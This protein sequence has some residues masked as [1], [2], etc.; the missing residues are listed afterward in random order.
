MNEV[1]LE[2]CDKEPI[3][4]PGAVQPHGVL[5]ALQSSNG[6]ISHLSENI[7]EVF[8]I[9]AADLLGKPIETLFQPEEAEE[10]MRVLL[11]EVEDEKP[12]YLYTVNI[13]NHD[14]PFDAIAHRNGEVLFIEFEP[15]SQRRDLS[16]P[17]LYRLVQQSAIRMQQSRVVEDLMRMCAAQVRKIN[18]FDRVMIYR[19]D[20]EW[21]G[22]VLAED[23]RDDLEPFLNLHYPASDIPK[24]ARELY[25]KNLLRFITSR[26]YKPA[27]ILTGPDFDS[28][29]PLDLSFSVLRSVSPIHLEYLRNMGVWA[30]MS[31]SLIKDGRLWGLIAC[32]HY[33]GPRF[34]SYD[35]R[36]ACELLG[37][38]LSLH[39]AVVEE[40]EKERAREEKAVVRQELINAL[41]RSEDLIQALLKTRPTMLDLIEADGA[42]IVTDKS[43]ARIGQTPGPDEIKKLCVWL[44]EH[45]PDEIIAID[46]LDRAFGSRVFGNVAA[47]VLAITL[48][49]STRYKLLWFRSELIRTVNWA[50]DPAK[51]VTKGDGV[52]RLSPRGSFALWKETIKGRCIP[53]NQ[54]NLDAAQL[55]HIDLTKLLLKRTRV[56]ELAHANL[57]IASEEREKLLDSERAA[58]TQADR[59][60]RIKDDFLA[61]LSHELR[62]P[63]NSILGW[64]VLLLDRGN[65]EDNVKDGLKVI[66]RSARS[67]AG[68]IEDLLDMSRII[69]GKLRLDLQ[70]T[71]L[72]TVV[73]ASIETVKLAADAKDIRVERLIDPL[74]GLETTGDP[75]R[76]Q[77][78]VWNLL[79]NAVKFTP[80]KG[81]I[82]LFLERVDSHVELTVTDNGQGIS[83]IELPYIF[84]RFHQV[85]NSTSRQHGGLGLGL[86]I[87]RNLVELHGGTIRASSPGEGK[88]ATF[89]VAL[90]VRVLRHHRDFEGIEDLSMSSPPSHSFT[91][92]G[93]NVLVVDDEDDARNLIRRMLE[94]YECQVSVVGSKQ[95]AIELLSTEK[96]DVLI[97][98]IGM[99]GED[100]YTLIKNWRKIESQ[101][102]KE[103]T[104]AIAL[105]AYVRSKDRSHSLLSGFQAHLGKPVESG[106][107]LAVV[108][109]LTGRI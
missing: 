49:A 70:P 31:V 25:T 91:L 68:M 29:S 20:A 95:E 86:S 102:G 22:V 61:T 45:S 66:E 99:P 78:I 88:G 32:H 89:V 33:D 75:N 21:N 55:L 42:A 67:Q 37:Q 106:E 47:G 92:S 2:N 94:D 81:K 100:G 8:G 80:K 73:E 12:V 14:T 11:R 9:A 7:H 79:S 36:T 46:S 53:W 3:H 24:Q 5:V 105:T 60:N 107:L 52:A 85:D 38:Q 54:R 56:L 83:E 10:R 35:V 77:Q 103:R 34:V 87:V 30:S 109:S 93:L 28:S 43:F 64:S 48:E 96:F 39:L 98:D 72:P 51:T 1:T 62:N 101:M 97:S 26:D 58:R 4:I 65:L 16:A 44:D 84:D 76:L 41:E 63:L 40:A 57:R 19:F 6:E 23:K 13:R 69:S 15:S 104:P 50:G 17:G 59:V 18:G 90:P 71:H 82:Q 108:A 74:I 27:R